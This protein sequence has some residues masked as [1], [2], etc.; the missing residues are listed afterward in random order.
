MLDED[1]DVQSAQRDSIHVKKVHRQADGGGDRD[2]GACAAS[3]LVAWC[4]N[5]GF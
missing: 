5:W 2:A 3:K 1:Q 4:L